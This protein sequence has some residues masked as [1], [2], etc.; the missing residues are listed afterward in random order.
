MNSK[1]I[2]AKIKELQ[3]ELTKVDHNEKKSR[4]VLNP[5]EFCLLTFKDVDEDT[6]KVTDSENPPVVFYMTYTEVCPVAMNECYIE[7][8]SPYFKDVI[9]AAPSWEKWIPKKISKEEAFKYI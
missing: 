1:E 4:G 6:S 5:G 2:A 8:Y 9:D 3:L 7:W